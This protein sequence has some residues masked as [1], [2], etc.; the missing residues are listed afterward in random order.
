MLKPRLPAPPCISLGFRLLPEYGMSGGWGASVAEQLPSV[1]KALGQSLAPHKTRQ[2][3][4]CGE[5][6]CVCVYR[7]KERET[8][9]QI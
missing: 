9:R 3:E 2:K 1:S 6:V 7:E 5:C 4:V 8:D